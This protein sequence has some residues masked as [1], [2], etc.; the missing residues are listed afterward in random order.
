MSAPKDICRQWITLVTGLKCIFADDPEPTAPRPNVKSGVTTYASM[1]F[2]EDVSEYGEPGEHTSDE[3]GD[4][5][6][7]KVKQYR[8]ETVEGQLLVD[9]Y[10]PGATDY[11][12]A[13]RLSRGR[14][15]V[16][17]LID[18]SGITIKRPSAVSDEP[19]LRDATREPAASISFFVQWVESEITEIEPVESTATTV[20]VT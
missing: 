15:D 13:L 10:G 18:A 16:L 4:T 8:G 5:D 12:R 20:E 9:I 7:T 2:E 11:A 1:L 17:Q 6:P 19:L 14:H 3:A